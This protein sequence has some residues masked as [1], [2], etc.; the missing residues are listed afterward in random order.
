MMIKN[1]YD[2]IDANYLVKYLNE[3]FNQEV[4]INQVVIP[5]NQIGLNKR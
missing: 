4:E 2:R 3:N 1:P 5:V